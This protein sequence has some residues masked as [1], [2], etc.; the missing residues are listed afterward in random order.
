MI[1]QCFTNGKVNPQYGL[2]QIKY[3]IRRIKP[4]KSDTKVDDFSS[5]YIYNDVN[6]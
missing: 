2:V 3:D 5:K 6:I 1:T 4:Y